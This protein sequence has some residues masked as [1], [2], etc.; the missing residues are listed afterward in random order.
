V[1]ASILSVGLWLAGPP[2]PPG[3]PA[4]LPAV[5][6]WEFGGGAFRL[7]TERFLAWQPIHRVGLG[8]TVAFVPTYYAELA[9][10]RAGFE[11]LSLAIG[12]ASSREGPSMVWPRV[13]VRLP[14]ERTHVGVAAP[15]IAYFSSA[16]A[17]GATRFV[18]PQ[19]WISGRF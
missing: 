13:Q 8:W 19:A 9:P 2:S 11:R 17:V 1:L 5:G 12:T 6:E 10:T 18:R 16:A 14:D 3:P 4:F 15:F 7:K